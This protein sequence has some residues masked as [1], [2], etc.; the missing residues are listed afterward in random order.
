[1]SINTLTY[2]LTYLLTLYIMTD[3]SH[4]YDIYMHSAIPLIATDVTVA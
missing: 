1:M 2:L 3:F 4:R